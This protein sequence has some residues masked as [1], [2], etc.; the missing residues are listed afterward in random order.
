MKKL[1]LLLLICL[2]INANPKHKVGL[3]ITATNKYIKFVEPLIQS[4][5]KHF[6]K[7]HDVTYFV[8]T[9]NTYECGTDT[10]LIYLQHKPWPLSTM[11]RFEAYKNS[12]EALSGMDYIFACDADMLFLD[13]VGEEVLKDRV[14][15][16]HPLFWNNIEEGKT[17]YESNPI[18]T[19]YMHKDES[20]NYFAGGFYGGKRDE[21]LKIVETCS[22]NMNKDYA[23]NYIAIWHDE[24]HLN[25]YFT[26]NPP[27]VILEPSYCFPENHFKWIKRPFPFK[28][29]LLALDKDCNAMR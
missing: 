24:S 6:L 23:K 11:Q 18:S 12:K 22:T 3:C 2:Q 13:D 7:D 14:A 9:N 4:A 28:K 20:N 17:Q 16:C 19:A 8:F 21:F 5:R 15:V 27:T 10:R 26:N 29:I 25:R 1:I